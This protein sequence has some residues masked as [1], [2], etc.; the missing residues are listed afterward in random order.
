MYFKNILILKQLTMKA[1][2][3]IIIAC[4]L[5]IFY[6]CGNKKIVET[7]ESKMVTTNGITTATFKVWGNCDMCK[8][9]IEH[10]LKVE[11][12]NNAEWN[13]DS[14]M[15]TVSFDSTKISMDQVYKNISQVGYDTEKYKGDDNAYA[16]LPE[17]CQY[18]RR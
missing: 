13:V 17:C 15:I 16:S 9:T 10:S 12:I 5:L 11:G 18:E 6:S 7:S 8:E 1:N 4:C 3:L 14:K 2:F